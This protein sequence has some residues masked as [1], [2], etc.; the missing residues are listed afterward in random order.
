MNFKGT[1]TVR[2]HFNLACQGQD[3]LMHSDARLTDR[4]I[5]ITF[6]FL[7]GR[8]VIAVPRACSGDITECACCDVHELTLGFVITVAEGKLVSRH[9]NKVRKEMMTY[10]EKKN[11]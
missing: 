1:V 4:Y 9:A 10:F 6:T 3:L 7:T 2:D 5:H 8:C 11:F